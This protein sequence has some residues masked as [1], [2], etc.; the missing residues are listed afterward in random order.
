LEYD[1]WQTNAQSL[2]N[3]YAIAVQSLRNRCTIATQSLQNRCTNIA[4][5]LQLLRN[6]GA[7]ATNTPQIVANRRE[8]TAK[9]LFYQ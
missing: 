1:H 8:I 7:I 2:Y 3:R 4:Q 6:H 5:S 9:A